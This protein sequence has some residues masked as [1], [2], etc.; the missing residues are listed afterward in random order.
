MKLVVLIVFMPFLLSACEDGRN[1]DTLPPAGFV[2]NSLHGKKL[3]QRFCLRCHGG[4]QRSREDAP[5]LFAQR[6]RIN[7]FRDLRF[8]TAVRNGVNENKQY[9]A[10]PA[11]PQIEARDTAH[12]VAFIR[13]TQQKNISKP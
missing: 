11:M 6:Y 12:I 13:K 4:P 7:D 10:M 9:P 2:G 1:A 3:Y 8:Y 5:Y